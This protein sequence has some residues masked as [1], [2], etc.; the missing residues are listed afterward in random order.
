MKR[1]LFYIV[2]LFLPTLVIAQTMQIPL[3]GYKK[4]D[5]MICQLYDNGIKEI[6]AIIEKTLEKIT[7]EKVR[8]CT[9][10]LPRERIL[11]N[12]HLACEYTAGQY[13]VAFTNELPRDF[14][15]KVRQCFIEKNVIEVVINIESQKLSI[16]YI[17]I[18]IV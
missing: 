6:Y 17:L 18:S 4:V 5:T 1:I 13:I 3:K 14:D 11:I 12:D 7:T 9:K 2:L 15:E 16:F 8:E 10:L